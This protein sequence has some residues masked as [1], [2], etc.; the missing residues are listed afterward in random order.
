MVEVEEVTISP[1]LPDALRYLDL[2]GQSSLWWFQ[3]SYEGGV[4]GDR[5]GN[6]AS[7]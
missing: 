3:F 2:V 7:R 4:T 1:V 6:R 5:Q